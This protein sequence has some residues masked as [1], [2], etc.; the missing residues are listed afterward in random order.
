MSILLSRDDVR[1]VMQLNGAAS[2]F[3]AEDSAETFN[4]YYVGSVSAEKAGEMNGENLNTLSD[5]A[6]GFFKLNGDGRR[7]LG[8][9]FGK[10]VYDYVNG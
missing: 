10:F 2:D 9:I 6:A 5:I 4:L 7:E 1:E 8:L 3:L